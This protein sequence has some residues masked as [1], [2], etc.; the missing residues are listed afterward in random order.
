EDRPAVWIN[1]PTK[2]FGEARPRQPDL[3]DGVTEMPDGQAG[4]AERAILLLGMLEDEDLDAVIE[5][6]N[7]VA[8]ARC[9]RFAASLGFGAGRTHDLVFHDLRIG[10]HPHGFNRLTTPFGP[11]VPCRGTAMN[12]DSASKSP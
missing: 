2:N 6:Y 5:W 4:G 7:R 10:S 8:R 9:S 11:N 12:N 3:Q 1:R